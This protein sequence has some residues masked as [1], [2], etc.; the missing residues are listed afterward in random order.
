MELNRSREDYLKTILIIEQ[1]KGSVRSSE[2]AKRLNVTRASVSTAV[3]MM[4]EDGFLAMDEH[5]MLCLTDLGRET[6]E[7]VY[8]RHRVIRDVLIL[9]G[10]EPAFAEEDACRIEHDVSG[11]TFERLRE[12]LEECMALDYSLKGNRNETE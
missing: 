2:V 1:E 8:E 3:H 10:V 6:A 5:R 12:L 9:L 4:K 11:Q 7:R